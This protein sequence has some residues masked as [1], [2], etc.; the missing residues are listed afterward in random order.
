[1]GNAPA[2]ER[3]RDQSDST[4]SSDGG[5]VWFSRMNWMVLSLTS[6]LTLL[7]PTE[8]SFSSCRVL[9]V[10]T[11]LEVQHLRLVTLQQGEVRE[12]ESKVVA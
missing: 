2:G 10:M 9:L 6:F 8:R 11:L 3:E 7:Y 5:T 4:I 12:R 1:M